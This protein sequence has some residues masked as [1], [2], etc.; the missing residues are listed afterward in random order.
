MVAAGQGALFPAVPFN[1]TIWPASTQPT[2][3][4]AEIVRVT[5]ISTDTLTITRAQESTSARTVI[6]GDQI[7]QTVTAKLFTDL[8]ASIPAVLAPTAVKTGAYNAQ[9]GD[10]VP[11]DVSAGTFA[12]TLPTAPADKTQ[13]AVEVV[14]NT[15]GAPK[16][17]TVVC[18][19][20]DV[21]DVASGATTRYMGLLFATSIFQYKASG[22]IWY[23]VTGPTLPVGFEFGYDQI[24]AAVNVSS[25]AVTVISCAAHSFDGSAVNVTFT[26]PRVISGTASGADVTISLYEAAPVN[27]YIGRMGWVNPNT[28]TSNQY[29][30]TFTYPHLT[31][32]AGAHTYQIVAQTSDTTGPPS[33]QAGAGGNSPTDVP[34]SVRFTKA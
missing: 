6:V 3:T 21:F 16:L 31:P 12:V 19:G 27:D 4:N 11:C 13:V 30:V 26:S 2:S 33:V 1:A 9:A 24:T 5:N 7:A 18:G 29:G 17:L 15:A 23:C 22:A 28:A 34:A 25:A 8:T 32:S 14:V 20:S 10:F